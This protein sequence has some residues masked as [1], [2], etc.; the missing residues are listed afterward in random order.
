ME[1]EGSVVVFTD[2]VVKTK[3]CIHELI[4][5]SC[6]LYKTVNSLQPQ[7]FGFS[8]HHGLI[9]HRKIVRGYLFG[10]EMIR[11]YKH[12][13]YLLIDLFALLLNTTKKIPCLLKKPFSKH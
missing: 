12:R 7:K 5:I 10:C 11:S 3:K 2:L 4:Y 6:K 9:S 13:W 1:V 8:I